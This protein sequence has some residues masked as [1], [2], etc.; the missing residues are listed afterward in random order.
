MSPG[1]GAR[2]DLP[3]VVSVAGEAE[4]RDLVRC[5]EPAELSFSAV[6][7]AGEVVLAEGVAEVAVGSFVKL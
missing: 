5:K 3:V 2:E 7:R 6:G 4:G 1:S